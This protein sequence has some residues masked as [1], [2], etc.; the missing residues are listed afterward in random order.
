VAGDDDDLGARLPHGQQRLH[1][2]LL[3]G[4]GR[5]RRIID[6]TCYQ[7]GVNLVG[8]GDRRDLG[9][10]RLLLIESVA[11]LERL[12]DMPVGGVQELHGA[13][14]SFGTSESQNGG[15]SSSAGSRVI[16]SGAGPSAAR[17][18]DAHSDSRVAQAGNG[19]SM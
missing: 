16:R 4:R 12:A 6:I 17:G 18:G 10:D 15:M 13:G 2:D 9:E 7:N 5:R 19:N 11:A 3:S 8:L 14:R 1:H